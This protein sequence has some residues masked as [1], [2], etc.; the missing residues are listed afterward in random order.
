MNHKTLAKAESHHKLTAAGACTY[1]VSLRHLQD[2]STQRQRRKVYYSVRVTSR[3]PS[4]TSPRQITYASRRE[5]A[6]ISVADRV[7][8]SNSLSLEA[9]ALAA[10]EGSAAPVGVVRTAARGAR[11][12]V[13]GRV[14]QA[15][16][17]GVPLGASK[18]VL[19]AVGLQ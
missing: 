11:L 2:L 15:T 13:V 14:V 19:L 8:L 3:P 4:L 17:C 6:E 7:L 9:V 12:Q 10:V 18:V 16:L 1:S 5:L